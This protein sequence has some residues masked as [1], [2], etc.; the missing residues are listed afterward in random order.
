MMRAF[1][2]RAP[3]F[4]R[5]RRGT[6]GQERGQ[7][8]LLV[9]MREIRSRHQTARKHLGFPRVVSA[10]SAIKVGAIEPTWCAL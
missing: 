2:F 9:V 7:D 4:Y 1:E 8:N 5:G 3:K 10:C 6:R